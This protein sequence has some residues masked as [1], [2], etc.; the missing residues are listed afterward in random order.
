LARA[1]SSRSDSVVV[2][3]LGRFGGA[4]ADAL[5]RLGH[6]VLGIDE[7]A[8]LVQSWADR[9]THVVQA[10]TTNGDTLRRLGVHEFDRAVVGI[11]TDMRRA[12]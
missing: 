2:I 1:P 5:V 9:L 8:A 4:V 10:D 11:G 3:G 7:D 6:D 12:C